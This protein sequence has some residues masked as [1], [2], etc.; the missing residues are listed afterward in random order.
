MGLKEQGRWT[1]GLVLGV[2]RVRV[3]LE[4]AMEPK[5]TRVNVNTKV[6]GT[7]P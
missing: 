4:P 6:N 5:G 3:T 1:P 2:R 7:R